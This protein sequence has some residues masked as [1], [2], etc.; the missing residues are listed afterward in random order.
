MVS[1]KVGWVPKI[2]RVGH[3]GCEHDHRDEDHRIAELSA[4]SHQTLADAIP[5]NAN[6]TYAS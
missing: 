4:P 6:G 3:S 2:G 1:L 5:P